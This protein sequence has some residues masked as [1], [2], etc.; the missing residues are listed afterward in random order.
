VSDFNTQVIEEF[1]ANDGQ[2]GGYFEGKDLII[3]T[4]TGAKS[5]QPRAVPLVFAPDGDKLLII[6]SAGGSDVNPGWYHN[7]V[8][9]PRFTAEVGGETFAVD[10][11]VLEGDERLRGFEILAEAN[12]GFRDYQQKTERVIPVIELTRVTE[13]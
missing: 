5:G 9:N 13:K 1:R 10:S 3:I 11:R 4:V 12:P 7:L 6:A 8:A 2:V